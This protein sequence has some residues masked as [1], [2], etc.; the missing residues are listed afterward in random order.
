[1]CV[2]QEVRCTGCNES[3]TSVYI[4]YLVQGGK[5]VLAHIDCPIRPK[6]EQIEYQHEEECMYDYAFQCPNPIQTYPT[7]YPYSFYYLHATDK[8]G[9]EKEKERK[10][11]EK[12][13]K[14]KNK[15]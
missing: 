10:G 8:K 4:L 13:K 15:W 3:S 2:E 11:K 5:V 1:M 7:P 14:K 9:K 6:E 12:E